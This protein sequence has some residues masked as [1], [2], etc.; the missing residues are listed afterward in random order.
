MCSEQ[1]LCY[2]TEND[3]ITKVRG[4]R[5]DY[6]LTI[7]GRAETVVRRF[8]SKQVFLKILQISQENI[9]VGVTI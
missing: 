2:Y 5:Y 1:F 8:P 6:V 9:Y 4:R 3:A 7:L